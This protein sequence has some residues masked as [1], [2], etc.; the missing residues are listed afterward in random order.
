MAGAPSLNTLLTTK[1]NTPAGCA[2]TMLICPQAGERGITKRVLQVTVFLN[3]GRAV[4]SP[5]FQLLGAGE[6]AAAEAVGALLTEG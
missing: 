1:G 6:G 4:P 5:L 2:W 3:W